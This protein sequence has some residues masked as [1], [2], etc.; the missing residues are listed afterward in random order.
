MPLKDMRYMF[1][2]SQNGNYF[3]DDDDDDE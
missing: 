1:N 2:K 3:D